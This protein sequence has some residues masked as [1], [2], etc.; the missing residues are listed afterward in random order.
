MPRPRDPDIP[1]VESDTYK[2]G[3]ARAERGQWVVYISTKRVSTGLRATKENVDR[4]KKIIDRE[5]QARRLGG[6]TPASLG[7]TQVPSLY[8]AVERWHAEHIDANPNL[9]RSYRQGVKDAIAMFMGDADMPLGIHPGIVPAVVDRFSRIKARG[10]YADSTVAR[11]LAHWKRIF[12]WCQ[13]MGWI[14]ANPI[15]RLS[16]PSAKAKPKGKRRYTPTETRRIMREAYHRDPE[17]YR[18]LF[19]LWSTGM[20]IHEAI[21]MRWADISEH[22]IEIRG[23]GYNGEKRLRTFTLPPLAEGPHPVAKWRRRID[24]ILREQMREASERRRGTDRVW[25]W[26][27]QNSARKVLNAAKEAVDVPTNDRRSF[28]TLRAMAIHHMRHELGFAKG[29]VGRICGNSD[30]VI[31]AHYDRDLE[32]GEALR[33]IEDVVKGRK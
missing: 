23:K 30:A 11:A 15:D 24:W 2:L 28:H 21:D 5:V 8:S 31:D 12:G 13:S 3:Y 29:F 1:R 22:S 7:A 25:R 14:T 18:L 19:F 9:S 26:S 6:P 27:D 32:T 17:L 20:R 16:V 10:G 33:Y 4:V